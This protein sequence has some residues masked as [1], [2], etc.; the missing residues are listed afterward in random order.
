MRRKNL[1]RRSRAACIFNPMASSVFP[2]LLVATAGL[3]VCSVA[4][5]METPAAVPQN[6]PADRFDKLIQKSPFAPATAPPSTAPEDKGFA[7]NLFLSSVAAIDDK[8]LVTISSR[9]Q[10]NKVFLSTGED[11]PDGM[12]LVSVRYSEEVGKSTAVVKKGA[13][14]A[15]LE[16]DQAALQLRAQMAQQQQAQPA[17]PRPARP[18]PPGQAG[19]QQPATGAGPRP[20]R[21]GV[22]ATGAPPIPQQNAITGQPMPPQ[23]GYNGAAQGYSAGQP[24][25]A[26]QPGVPDQRRRIRIINSRPAE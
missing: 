15:T 2:T 25:Q 8:Y 12:S 14:T 6:W 3:A 4:Q 10:P 24:V 20:L 19:Y 11:G 1:R 9:E 13:E 21:A 17:A 22:P 16:F 23:P 26:G 7:A 5:A 18:I